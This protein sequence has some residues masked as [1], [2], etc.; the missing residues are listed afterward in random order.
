MAVNKVLSSTS[1]HIEVEAEADKTGA[2][3]YKK[4]FSGV[5]PTA[6]P[7]NVFD[8]A[9]AIKGVLS[10]GIKDSYLNES[11]KLVNA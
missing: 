10:A 2:K 5:I 1:F 7:Q 4:T 3:I 6:T 9:E 8:V 11:S